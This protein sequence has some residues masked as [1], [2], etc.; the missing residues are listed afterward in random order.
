M[1]AV[2]LLAS[3]SAFLSNG[4]HPWAL[5]WGLVV[6]LVWG[7][8]LGAVP[9]SLVLLHGV[10]THRL[11]PRRLFAALL[12]VLYALGYVE[13]R[14]SHRLIHRTT[15]SGAEVSHFVGT[16]DPGMFNMLPL[17]GV[18]FLI[19]LP[20]CVAEGLTWEVLEL[21]GHLEPRGRG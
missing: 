4:L 13:A 8:M 17:N 15:W 9:A 20:A 21:G 12:V 10:W 7:L 14:R 3:L 6:G 5:G 1:G 16:G 18:L 2:A 11:V 19:F